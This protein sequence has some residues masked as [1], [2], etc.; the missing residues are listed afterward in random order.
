MMT[1]KGP[2]NDLDVSLPIVEEQARVDKRRVLTGKV[3]VRT[4]VESVDDAACAALDR[5][6]VI[7]TR[8]PLNKEVSEAPSIRTEGDLTIV[9][10]LEEIMVVEKRLVLKEEIHIRRLVTTED[11]EVPIALKKQRA[12]VERINPDTKEDEHGND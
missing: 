3:R 10:V 7:V 9:P 1:P 12:L 11:V 2:T 4:V 8:V 6:D 5:Q